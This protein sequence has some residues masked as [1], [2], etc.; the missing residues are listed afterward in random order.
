MHE[1]HKAATL[2]TPNSD[3]KTSNKTA[4][5]HKKHSMTAKEPLAAKSC[6]SDSEYIESNQAAVKLLHH[7]VTAPQSPKIHFARGL[8]DE[9]HSMHNRQTDA[10]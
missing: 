7:R 6:V 5:K 1:T 2:R 9:I 3:D 4:T 8:N 10:K